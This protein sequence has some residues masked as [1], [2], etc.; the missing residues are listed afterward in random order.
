MGGN[1]QTQG[2][3][4]T[5]FLADPWAT[6]QDRRQPLLKY[7]A[8]SAEG[9]GSVELTAQAGDVL[10]LPCSGVHIVHNMEDVLAVNIIGESATS[11]KDPGSHG[12]MPEHCEFPTKRK[13]KPKENEASYLAYFFG[14]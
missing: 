13:P 12:W 10:F 2:K 5:V 7:A 6:N 1:S 11:V 14:K 9:S 3:S 4:D 8:P